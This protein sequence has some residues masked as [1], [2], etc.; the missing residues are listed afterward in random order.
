MDNTDKHILDIIQTDFPLVSRPYAH[1]GSQVGLTQG[2][3][4]ARVRAMQQK[5][6]I[7]RIGANFQSRRLGW[8]STL[9]AAAVPEDKLEAFVA[10]VNS[11]PGVTHNYL[12]Q[13]T[14]NVWFT[15]IGPT[16]KDIEDSLAA[17]TKKTG[18]KVLNL[19]A[20]KMFKIRVDFR[21]QEE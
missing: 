6:I 8:K 21:M 15:F 13:H 20:E 5:G 19:P 1:I 4:L 10:L 2:E 9:C 18:I 17:I 7:R 14:Y 3:T 11:Y 12:R 16:W